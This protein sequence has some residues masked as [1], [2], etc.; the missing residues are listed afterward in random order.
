MDKSV[1]CGDN[2]EIIPP[3]KSEPSDRTTDAPLQT[4]GQVKGEMGRLYRKAKSGKMKWDEATR[5]IYVLRSLLKA[6]EIE[7]EFNLVGDNPDEDRPVLT[8]LQIV[9]PKQLTAPIKSHDNED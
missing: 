1:E 3:D 7:H 8:G 9:G 6:I 4:V 5:A 2:V